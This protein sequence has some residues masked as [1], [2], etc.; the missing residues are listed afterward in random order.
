MF[1]VFHVFLTVHLNVILGKDQLDA[2]PL[3]VFILRLYMFRAA[4]AHHQKGQILLI[5]HLV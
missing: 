4:S 3:N 2:L 5:Q 1:Y